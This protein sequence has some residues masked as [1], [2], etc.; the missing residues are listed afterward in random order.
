MDKVFLITGCNS[1]LG[2][3]LTQKLLGLKNTVIGISKTKKKIFNK[4]FHY[5]KHDLRNK[6][7]DKSIK[8]IN[9]FFKNK[10]KIQIIIN[11]AVDIDDL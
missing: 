8:K 3:Q 1:G 2:Y 10:N 5:I 11:A 6:I 7:D 4:Q 9:L